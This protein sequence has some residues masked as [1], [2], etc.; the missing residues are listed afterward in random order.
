MSSADDYQI[1]RNIRVWSKCSRWQR[2]RS[3]SGQTKFAEVPKNRT[4]RKEE[5]RSDYE[6]PDSSRPQAQRGRYHHEISKV[7]VQFYIFACCIR[8][9]AWT[10]RLCAHCQDAGNQIELIRCG[11]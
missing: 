1:S 2:Q 11:T 6:Q 10:P 5:G 3:F 9:R 8:D 7:V 4:L